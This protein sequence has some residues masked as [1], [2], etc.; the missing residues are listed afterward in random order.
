MTEVNEQQ[1]KHIPDGEEEEVSK[2]SRSSE[3]LIP[4]APPKLAPRGI[5]AFTVFRESDETGVSGDGVVIEGVLLAT[6]Q[7]VAHWLYPPPR[8]SIAVFDSID[9]FIKVHIGP[10]P[11]NNTIITFQ[12][13]EQ[14]KF[15]DKE[16]TGDSKEDEEEKEA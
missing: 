15:G 3:D 11:S 7:C 16:L 8:G 6:G 2:S 9:D 1:Q 12:D 13:G 10:H 14:L 4:K 5:T